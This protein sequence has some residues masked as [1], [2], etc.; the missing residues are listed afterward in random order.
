MNTSMSRT[1]RLAFTVLALAA[2]LAA[3]TGCRRNADRSVAQADAYVAR[4]QYKEAIIEYRRA[5]QVAPRRADIH[6]RLAKAYG[7][8][9]DL[10]AAYESYAAAADLDPSLVDAQVQAGQLLLIAGEFGRAKLAAEAAIAADGTSVP[11]RILMGN[12]L[13]GLKNTKQA[14]KQMEEAIALDPSSAPAHSALGSVQF[15]SGDKSARA[16]FEKAVALQPRAIGSRIALANFDWAAGDRAAAEQDLEAALGVDPQN[17]EVHRALAL[18]YLTDRRPAEAE[19]HFK[20]LASQSPE[21]ALALADYY[22]GIGRPDE[23]LRIL[24][25]LTRDGKLGP[26]ARMRTA[27]AL[28]QQG[29]RTEALAIAEALVKERPFDA[30]AHTL[31]ARLLLS[32]PADTAA[33]WIEANEAVKADQRSAPAHY[34]LGLAALARNDLEAADAA[35]TQALKMNPRAAAAQL[36]LAK[37]RLAR[38]D[39]AAALNAAEDVVRARPDDGEATVVLARSLRARGDLERA[40]RELTSAIGR[41]PGDTTDTA[42]LVELGRVELAS[43]RVDSARAAFERALNARP[44]TPV[45]DDARA[46]LIAADLAAH[47]TAKARA[48]LTRWLAASPPDISVQ[49]LAARVDLAENADAAADK[50]LNEIIRARPD[51]LDAYELL[52]AHYVKQGQTGPALDKYRA[53]AA[54]VPDNPGPATMVGIL[55]EASNDRAGARAQ[56]EST[57]AR[58]PRAGAA[59]NNLAWMLAEDGRLDEALRWATVAAD[60]M[61]S[62]PE[63]HDTLGWIRLKMKQPVEALASFELATALAPQNRVYQDHVAAARA[64]LGLAR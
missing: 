46:G 36:Q 44:A 28:R 42:M 2:V 7:A 20:I 16:A 62:R 4:H 27:A 48:R 40:R 19:P 26:V 35:F 56:Y 52:A 6:Y 60:E 13:A 59:A 61:R 31:K 30:D 63:P 50:R 51:R 55:L 22:A 39:T 33:A 57:L 15:A 14:M 11:A 34:T 9:G 53:L 5:I 43:N 41:I 38:G 37:V 47:D 25:P 1:S 3:G 45:R 23:T 58:A 24:E 32:A 18:L 8:A 49:V 12:A 10:P 54:R 17:A 21:G 29:H 64:A